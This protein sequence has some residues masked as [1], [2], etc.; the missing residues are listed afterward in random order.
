MLN[1]TET[2]SQRW[3]LFNCNTDTATRIKTGIKHLHVL[4][5]Q[6]QQKTRPQ[7]LPGFQF[8]EAFTQ[9][10]IQVLWLEKF[11]ARLSELLSLGFLVTFT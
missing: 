11:Y 3:R 5:I 10:K 7:H 4:A 1:L 8:Q 2:N 6:P 9:Q